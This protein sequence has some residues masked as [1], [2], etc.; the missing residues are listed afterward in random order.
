MSISTT[1]AAETGAAPLDRLAYELLEGLRVPLIREFLDAWPGEPLRRR[2]PPSQTAPVV[3]VLAELRAAAPDFSALFIEQ[4][5]RRATSLSWRRTYRPDEVSE[6]F[7]QGYAYCEL[8]GLSGAVP[9]ERLACG[10]LLLAS[11]LIYGSHV[12]EAEEIYVPLAGESSWQRDAGAWV[13][14]APGEVIHHLSHQPH[15]MQ[16]HRSGL[17]A[18]YLWRSADLAQKARLV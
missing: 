8:L 1:A 16:T 14:R 18:L 10:V 15:S 6:R 11:N 3:R 17:C 9:S 5:A 13:E 12:H 4:L 2:T 7:M